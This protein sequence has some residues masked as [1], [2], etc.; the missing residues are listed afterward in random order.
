M[1]EQKVAV[2]ALQETLVKALYYQVRMNGYKAYQNN[3]GE[4]F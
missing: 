1:S 3:A 4:D 2:L